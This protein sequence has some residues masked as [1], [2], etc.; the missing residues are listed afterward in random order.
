MPGL[1]ALYGIGL[2]ALMMVLA[3]SMDPEQLA[4]CVESG[5]WN[6]TALPE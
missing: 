5:A 3:H 2:C 6:S 4:A 1:I